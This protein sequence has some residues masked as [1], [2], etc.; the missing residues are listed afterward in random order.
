M[1][2]FFD[3]GSLVPKSISTLFAAPKD[4][5]DAVGTPILISVGTFTW[6]LIVIGG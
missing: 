4:D 5:K 6:A 3:G 2:W 1:Q